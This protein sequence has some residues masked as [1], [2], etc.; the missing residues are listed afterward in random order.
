MLP[1]VFGERAARLGN[2]IARQQMLA[3]ELAVVELGQH[4]EGRSTDGRLHT[5]VVRREGAPLFNVP[6]LSSGAPTTTTVRPGEA[7]GLASVRCNVHPPRSFSPS[8]HT[9]RC[10]SA[11]AL[12]TGDSVRLR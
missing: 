6:L 8:S 4:I 10:P 12:A 7:P 3:P 5:L 11:M 1:Q 9:D 2:Q